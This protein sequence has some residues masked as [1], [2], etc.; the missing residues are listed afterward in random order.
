MSAA[1]AG[2]SAVPQQHRV[3]S[4]AELAEDT[5]LGVEISGVPV[6]V[7]RT[8]GTVYALRDECSHADVALSAGEVEDGKIE[9]WLHG[10]QF[11]LATG[12]PLTLPAIDPVPTYPVTIDGDDVLVTVA[13][14]SPERG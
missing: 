10:S 11:D 9:C 7:V 12:V 1:T 13:D 5:A 14:T 4:L 2:T 3:C 8:G 6:C